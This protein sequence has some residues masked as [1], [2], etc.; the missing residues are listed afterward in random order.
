MRD[1]TSSRSPRRC[2][3]GDSVQRRLRAES[4]LRESR[5]ELS[6]SR[7]E[8]RVLAGRL[9]RAQEDE[10]K[11]VARELHDDLSQRLSALL[12]GSAGLARLAPE[13]ASVRAGF[14]AHQEHL[15]E[16]VEEVRRLAYDLHPAILTHLGLRAALQSFCVEFS[17]REEI[18]VDFSAQKEPAP[19]RKRSPPASTA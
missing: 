8:L 17:A 5:Q 10:R 4:S 19:C 2:G 13:G 7:A 6:T 11:R 3:R 14:E 1:I 9:I 12:L 18:D 15:A 16:V